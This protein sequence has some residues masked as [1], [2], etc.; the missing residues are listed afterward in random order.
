G[1]IAG[2][3]IAAGRSPHTPAAVVEN[4][5]LP[6]QR[7]ITA[8]LGELPGAAARAGISPPALIVIGDVVR[9]RDRIAASLPR[10]EKG[11]PSGRPKG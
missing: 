3:L 5:S 2:R 6:T 9:V 10:L 11:V 1:E 8:E 4:G 7:V